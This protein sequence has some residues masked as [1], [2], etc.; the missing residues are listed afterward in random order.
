MGLTTNNYVSKRT[1]MPLSTAYALLKT[2]VIEKNN[3][4]RATFSIHTSRDNAK[5]Y[6]SIENVT[7][8]FQWDRKC[9]VVKAAYNAAKNERKTVFEDGTL[10]E[11]TEYG[12][13]YGWDDDFYDSEE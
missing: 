6:D 4:V 2:L 12:I 11:I 13:L 3:S 7:V 5:S 1:N 10:N 9:D 8:H